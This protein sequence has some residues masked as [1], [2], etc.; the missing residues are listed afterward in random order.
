MVLLS[1]LY[2]AGPVK[3]F[4]QEQSGHIVGKG[5]WGQRKY[6]V[7]FFRIVAD[8]PKGPPMTKVIF[9]GPASPS[10]P[11]EQP[12]QLSPFVCLFYRGKQDRDPQHFAS[13]FH[14]LFLS[15]DFLV[16]PF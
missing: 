16:H 9:F 2:C 5:H 4:Q 13:G 11:F 6:K 10:A 14:F 3:L 15:E 1:C 7:G 8:R 12:V